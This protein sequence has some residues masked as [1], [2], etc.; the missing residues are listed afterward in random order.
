[1]HTLVFLLG[2]EP[3]RG[4]L[5]LPCYVVYVCLHALVISAG[6]KILG[7]RRSLKTAANGASGIARFVREAGVHY[8]GFV[9]CIIA[10]WLLSFF[11]CRW[12]FR[13]IHVNL[14]LSE[15]H[16]LDGSSGL[17]GRGT[18]ACGLARLDTAFVINVG[19][20]FAAFELAILM[21]SF[22]VF[23]RRPATGTAAA[24]AV[25]AAAFILFFP[26]WSRV[27][28]F[29]KS[30]EPFRHPSEVVIKYDE[31]CHHTGHRGFLVSTDGESY[32]PPGGVL[33]TT[34]LARAREDEMLELLDILDDGG[35]FEMEELLSPHSTSGGVWKT[36]EVTCG[37]AQHRV[38]S[39]DETRQGRKFDRMVGRLMQAMDLALP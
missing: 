17:W 20:L 19:L 13:L 34:L 16:F 23:R 3:S 7:H 24:G 25:A 6:V 28:G 5:D 15:V 29:L 21:R 1:M 33:P 4:L 10:A 9:G 38:V 37:T 39:Y 8:V 36:L 2:V 22:S 27:R 32:L 11:F 18:Y 26:A 14:V 30:R 35:F 12:P 31:D